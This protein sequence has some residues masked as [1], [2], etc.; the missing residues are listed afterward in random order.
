V[1]DPSVQARLKAWLSAV[2]R[3]VSSAPLT[4]VWLIVLLTTTIIQRNVSRLELRAMLV[5][6]STNIHELA[7]DPLQVLFTSLFWIEGR[8]WTPYLLLF[9]LFL[10]PAERWLGKI[11]WLTVGLTAHVGA[12]Y[13]SEG[14]LYLAILI[15]WKPEWLVYARD[16]G[17]SYFMV[18]V[19][20]VLAY[21]VAPP[22]RWGYLAVLITIFTVPL[23]IHLNFTAIGHFSAIFIGL[24]F[25]PMARGRGRPPVNP[26]K[27]KATAPKSG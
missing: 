19:I 10:A 4:Y 14:L 1:G 27:L 20:A 2:W 3:F 21:H 15:H 18:G 24:L 25:Y 12:T 16:I 8:Y 23:F 9:T 6:Q 11:R 17:V 5:H 7:A 26:A 22:W 13:I